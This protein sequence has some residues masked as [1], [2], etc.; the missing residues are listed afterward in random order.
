L[1]FDVFDGVVESLTKKRKKMGTRIVRAEAKK[2]R[3]MSQQRRPTTVRT[4]SCC[5]DDDGMTFCYAKIKKN[6]DLTVLD[7]AEQMFPF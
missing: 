6:Y 4:K 5:D 2:K 1:I 7:L 3:T